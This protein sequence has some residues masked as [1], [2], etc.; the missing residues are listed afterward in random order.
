MSNF[1]YTNINRIYKKFSL[2]YNIYLLLIVMDISGHAIS[3][4]DISGHAISDNDIS[5]HA[6]SNISNNILFGKNN[7]V[8]KNDKNKYIYTIL[9]RLKVLKK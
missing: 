5:G 9:K 4:N 3:D 6:I 2:N 8:D 7:K 1:G